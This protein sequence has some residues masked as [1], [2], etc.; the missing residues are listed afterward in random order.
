MAADKFH[1]IVR[2]GI[3]S[4]VLDIVNKWH[5]DTHNGLDRSTPCAYTLDIALSSVKIK[6]KS[7]CGSHIWLFICFIN[8]AAA[9]EE[10][11]KG[12]VVEIEGN[13]GSGKSTLIAN[14]VKQMETSQIFAEHVHATFLQAFYENPSRYGFA[15]QMYMLT[16]RIYQMEEA[17]RLAKDDGTVCF[18]DR[19]AVGDLLFAYYN[20]VLKNLTDTDIG[21]YKSVC[22]E[23]MPLS[24]SSHVDVL[25]YLDVDS[26]V[27]YERMKKRARDAEK[28]VPLEYL[29]GLDTAY[30]DFM[31]QWL[32]HYDGSPFAEYNVGKEP[33][34][35][36][37]VLLWNEFGTTD[38]VLDAIHETGRPSVRFVKYMTPLLMWTQESVDRA[39][40]KMEWP[41][42]HGIYL[43]WSIPHV[44]SYKRFV[45][46]LL[47]AELDRYEVVF[48]LGDGDK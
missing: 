4:I 36:V 10:K 2:G 3:E 29:Q 40:R 5:H 44:N 28:I 33:P 24:L 37:R 27:C 42:E 47:A 26:C 7:F 39:Q 8:M 46:R 31:M 17:A 11:R 30:F 35:C 18:L 23:R 1:N 22:A 14:L 25:V 20:R 43:P 16:T 19:G 41:T 32:G 38:A 13:V 34:A 48:V 6:T 21:I 15:F 45:M 9:C 12:L